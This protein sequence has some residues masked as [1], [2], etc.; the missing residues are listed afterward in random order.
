GACDSVAALAHIRWN[1]Y[2]REELACRS[3]WELALAG[4]LA[5][6]GKAVSFRRKLLT[7]FALTVF[8][9]VTLVT[10]IVSSVTRRAFEQAN[11]ERTAAL[12]AQ[13]RREFNRRGDEVARRGETIAAS[14]AV[15]N[16]GLTPTPWA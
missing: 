12:V 3:E 13:F 4:H 1:K 15:V 2:E 14:E 7:V 8:L 16:V 6:S 9:S 10:W 11:D 5:R